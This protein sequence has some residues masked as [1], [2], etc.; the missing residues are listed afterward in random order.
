MNALIALNESYKLFYE[1]CEVA[2]FAL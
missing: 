1:R 2:D